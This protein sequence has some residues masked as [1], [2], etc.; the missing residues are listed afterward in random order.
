MKIHLRRNNEKTLCGKRLIP[1][2]TSNINFQAV[3]CRTCIEV[4]KNDR[5]LIQEYKLGGDFNRFGKKRRFREHWSYRE[6]MEFLNKRIK[7][8]IEDLQYRHDYSVGESAL[9][10]GISLAIDELKEL[11][12]E[13]ES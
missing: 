10:A 1:P 13:K 5:G 3:T 2:L 11:L 7:T 9:M 6:R 8:I 4:Y 12:N